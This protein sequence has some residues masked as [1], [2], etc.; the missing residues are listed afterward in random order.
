LE[1]RI[2]GL[3]I[4]DSHIF[5][6]IFLK[7]FNGRESTVFASIWIFTLFLVVKMAG[8]ILDDSALSICSMDPWGW[9]MPNA[10]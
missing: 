9:P 7:P 6:G 8:T 3:Y 5:P 2:G 1:V 10:H 4:L